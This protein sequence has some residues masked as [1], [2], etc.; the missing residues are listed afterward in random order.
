MN[1][2]FLGIAALV[3]GILLGSWWAPFCK[4]APAVTP[5][6]ETT[7]PQFDEDGPTIN[8]HGH[9]DTETR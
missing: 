7:C 3:L 5:T 8:I 4:P 9:C 2:A 1:R 6:T